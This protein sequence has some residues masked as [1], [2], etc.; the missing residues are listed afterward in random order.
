MRQAQV[1]EPNSPAVVA[2]GS[3]VPTPALAM[4]PDPKPV[5]S[6][7]FVATPLLRRGSFKFV[8]FTDVRYN[9]IPL[10]AVRF[11]IGRCDT[12]YDLAGVHPI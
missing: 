5:V 9:T 10:D 2:D 11:T 8:V 1:P 4:L 12:A 3:Q 6:M 7:P